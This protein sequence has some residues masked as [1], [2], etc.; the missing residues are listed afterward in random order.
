LFHP[1]H[2]ASSMPVFRFSPK[3]FTSAQVLTERF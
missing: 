3:D 2:V 1:G